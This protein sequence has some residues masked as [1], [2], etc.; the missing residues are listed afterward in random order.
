MASV[1][2]RNS[3]FLVDEAQAFGLVK[4]QRMH[5]GSA[6]MAGGHNP[7]SALTERSNMGYDH[8]PSLMNQAPGAQAKAAAHNSDPFYWSGHPRK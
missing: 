3:G 2:P 8:G 1:D 5:P 4:E 7:V 6:C